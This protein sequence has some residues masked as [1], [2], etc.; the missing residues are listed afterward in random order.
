M[1]VPPEDPN[2]PPPPP[3]EAREIRPGLFRV[4]MPLPFALDHINLWLLQDE[5]GFTLIDTGIATAEVRAAWDRLAATV[6][7]DRPPIRLICTHFHPDHMGLAGWLAERWGLETWATLGEW[8]FGR[9]LSLEEDGPFTAHALAFYRGAGFDA[10][11][12]AKIE[13]RGNA[14]RKRVAPLPASFRRLH[15]DDRLCIGGREWQ[16]IVGRGHSPEHACLYSAEAGILIAGD[17]VLPKISPNISVWPQEPE[18]DS[19]ALYLDSL[20]QFARL[21]ADTLVLPSHHE[22]FHGLRARLEALAVHHHRRLAETFIA[23]AGRS[24]TAAQLVEVGDGVRTF[25]HA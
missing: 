20:P 2:G 17:Q 7:R 24:V 21:P 23:C 9:M 22:P 13:Q 18:A 14:Y 8:A 15:H 25:R 19:L 11:Q 3:G 4:R 12:L 6:L 5:G 16:V 1:D 10:G